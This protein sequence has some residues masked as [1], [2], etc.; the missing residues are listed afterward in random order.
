MKRTIWWAPE[1]FSP[2]ET[3]GCGI[4]LDKLS[5]LGGELN[6]V[7]ETDM[8]GVALGDLDGDG[9]PD[10]Y[11]ATEDIGIGTFV[12]N[13]AAGDREANSIPYDDIAESV[14]S[15]RIVDFEIVGGDRAADFSI[16][17]DGQ[18]TYTGGSG[19]PIFSRSIR[20]REN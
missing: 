20:Q 17:S 12:G 5:S 19:K 2:L 4:T 3:Q 8:V 13:A 18:I 7:S 6:V 10:M 15:D 14:G 1:S 11:A 16:N 9:G